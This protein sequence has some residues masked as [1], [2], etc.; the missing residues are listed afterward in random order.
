MH[1]GRSSS[2]PALLHAPQIA[3]GKGASLSLIYVRVKNGIG[4]A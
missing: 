3:A 1:K 2:G 4:F